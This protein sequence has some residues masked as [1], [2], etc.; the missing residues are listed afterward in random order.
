MKLTRS[1]LKQMIKEELL[2]EQVMNMRSA[3]YELGDKIENL[4]WLVDRHSDYK[5]DNKLK[6][7][8]KQFLKLHSNTLHKHLEKEYPDW[9]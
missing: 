2:K 5:G 3:F 9:D 1:K 6:T 4:L 8:G 7:I